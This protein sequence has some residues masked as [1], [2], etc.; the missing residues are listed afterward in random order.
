M[1][2]ANNAAKQMVFGKDCALVQPAVVLPARARA[3]VPNLMDGL[4]LLG[5]LADGAWPLCFF[6]PQYRGI[7]DKQKYGNEGERQ[8]GRAEL[9]QM[10]DAT[11]VNFIREIDRVLMPSG[12][13]ML[14][15]DK[16]HLCTG[17]ADW[18]R[19]TKLEIVDLITWNKLRMGMGYRTRRVSEHLMVLQKQPVRAKGIWSLHDIKD[20]WDEKAPA[21]THAKPI[22]LQKRLIECLTREGDF[23]L[24]PASGNYTVMAAAH[25]AGR[26]F[27][28]G[29]VSDHGA[30][31]V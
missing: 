25:Q 2:S 7:L 29:D 20:V 21:G 5:G 15:I 14:W 24:D 30:G 13:L 11:I 26:R 18:L 22:G 19:E 28:G 31:L 1:G 6:D 8:K 10:D 27:L 23:V 16:F 4:L 9:S 3:D 12:H 17:I